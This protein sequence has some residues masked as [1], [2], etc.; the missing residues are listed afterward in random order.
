MKVRFLIFIL[1]DSP[2][3]IR[4]LTNLEKMCEKYFPGEYDLTVIDI[5]KEPHMAEEYKILAIPTVIKESP[6]PARRI[7]GDMTD[8]GEVILGL[9]LIDIN[10]NTSIE[11]LK[12]GASS[13]KK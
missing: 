12:K 7:I 9:G 6:P 8:F 13:E 10:P 11:K 5:L 2:S 1:G 4:A 3:S